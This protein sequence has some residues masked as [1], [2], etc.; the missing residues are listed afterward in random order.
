MKDRYTNP[1][2]ELGS[3]V[4][5]ASKY[6]FWRSPKIVIAGLTRRIEAVYV[7]TPLALGVGAYGI[8][9][10]AG[11]EPYAVTAVLNSAPMSSYLRAAFHGKH[12][13]G[14]YLALNKSTIEQLPMA[15]Q[16]TLAR[17]ELAELSRLLHTCPP[18]R[19]QADEIKRAE[20][21]IDEIVDRLLC[22]ALIGPMLIDPMLIDQS[23][24]G[25]LRWR[26]AAMTV[27]EAGN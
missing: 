7:A 11:Y 18:A 23:D 17:T 10:L 12:L 8:Y 2:L 4:V 1:Y 26:I 3:P 6:R 27:R 14:G 24:S 22:A 9:D 5:A 13:A 25:Y 20:R 21:R 15:D 16:E 19:R